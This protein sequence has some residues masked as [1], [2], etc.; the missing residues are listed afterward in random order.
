MVV[1]LLRNK[2]DHYADYNEACV[3]ARACARAS[4]IAKR[5]T[6]RVR[7]AHHVPRAA[8]ALSPRTYRTSRRPPAATQST[9]HIHLAAGSRPVRLAQARN[10]PRR[11][12]PEPA[13]AA[14]RCAARWPAHPV[15]PLRNQST[16]S[17]MAPSSRSSSAGAAQI[18]APWFATVTV[19]RVPLC[20]GVAICDPIGESNLRPAVCF[21]QRRPWWPRQL[22][23]IDALQRD[24]ELS[25]GVCSTMCPAPDL[26]GQSC[27]RHHTPALRTPA[28]NA[29]E[30]PCPRTLRSHS[31]G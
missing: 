26:N 22:Q 6:A 17:R 15:C 12:R 23:Q 28:S 10:R 14:S 1:T 8:C 9:L 30:A 27:G 25:F 3:R 18:D 21:R 11:C 31:R 4:R 19:R 24:A 29:R 20:D 16:P 5:A 2:E 7:D 13:R